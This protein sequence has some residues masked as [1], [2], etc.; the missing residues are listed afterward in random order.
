MGDQSHSF[1]AYFKR[2]TSPLATLWLLSE[3]PM[4][5]YEICAAMKERSAGRFT[6]TILYPVLYRLEEQGYV[7]V[8]HTEVINNRA[9]SYY[10]ITE[11]GRAY[12]SK[13]LKEYRE[14]SAAFN[15]ILREGDGK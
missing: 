10:A 15:A 6:M 14:I 11:E 13:S 5:G 1:D 8:S 12:L 3:K 2:A 4:Y 9:R 7:V